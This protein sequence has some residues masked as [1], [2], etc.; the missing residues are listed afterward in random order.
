MGQRYTPKYKINQTST[1]INV[2]VTAPN[3]RDVESLKAT[4]VNLSNRD[5]GVCSVGFTFRFHRSVK[6]ARE[7]PAGI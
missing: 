4:L 7:F 6:F 1:E 3:R 5:W 2:E